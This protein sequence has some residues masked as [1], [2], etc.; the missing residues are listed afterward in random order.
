MTLKRERLVTD[1]HR[2]ARYA[3][4]LGAAA[5]LVLPALLPAGAT[6]QDRA[7]DWAITGRDGSGW[8]APGGPSDLGEPTIQYLDSEAH[9][10]DVINFVPGAQVSVGF[11][12]R[13]GETWP[14]GGGPPRALPAGRVSGHTMRASPQG[15]VWAGTPAAPRANANA[16]SKGPPVDAGLGRGTTNAPGTAPVDGAIGPTI[17]ATTAS[18]V[19][20]G[21]Q[22]PSAGIGPLDASVGPAAGSLSREVF[23]FLPY[24][25]LTDSSTTL[26][27][28]L[29]STVAYFSVGAD[30]AGNLKK[31]NSDG[32]AT[33]GW[34]GWTSSNMTSVI[35]AAHTNGARV[36]LTVSVFAWSTGQ[37]AL[38]AALLG[39]PAARANLARQVAAAVA[40]RGADGVNL[41]FEPV[42]AGYADAFTALVRNVRAE[43]D[44]I[45][46]G[47]QL[48]FDTTGQ[49]A[50]Y[51]IEDAT[52]PGGADAIFIMGYDYR[53]SSASSAGSISPLSG[54]VYDL[55]DTVAAYAAR[56][57]PTKLILGVPYY[58]RAWS[59]S[60]NAPHA[61]NISGT[62]YGAS[63]TAIYGVAA[64]L[65]AQH[66]RNYDAV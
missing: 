39:S 48:T 35:N 64:D 14:V 45:A 2:T 43:L 9:E 4:R 41:D 17:S 59:T 66:G 58:G 37:K 7:T 3:L 36:V 23:G 24:W 5:L 52:A 30:Q 31:Q 46:P 12:P 32:S 1:S 62:Q 40:E 47:Y 53:T 63:V 56:V 33:T 8:A 26:N 27:W 16:D 25:E 19:A 65:A 60:S 29:L 42:V 38:Q 18:F 49:I 50:N 10:R 11:T 22:A 6:A 28:P 54:P 55:T 34:A 13:A 44:A 61:A 51:P 20:S 21:V 57:S 15:S